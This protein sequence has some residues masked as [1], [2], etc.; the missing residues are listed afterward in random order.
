MHA[1]LRRNYKVIIP[2]AFLGAILLGVLGYYVLFPKEYWQARELA[3]NRTKWESQKVSNYQML[4]DLPFYYVQEGQPPVTTV[5]VVVRQSSLDAG[6]S[7]Q[8]ASALRRGV[9]HV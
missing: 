1:W 5:R 2:V 4:V 3:D 6:R 8:S 7:R 9:R